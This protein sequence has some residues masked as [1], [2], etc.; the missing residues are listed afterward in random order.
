MP[1]VAALSGR[2]TPPQPAHRF[3]LLGIALAAAGFVMLVL[4]SE[5]QSTGY[6]IGGILA[7]TAGI[8][9][10]APLGIRALAGVARRAPVAVRLALRDL[11]RYQARS[12]AALA[13][14]SLAIGIA[15]TIAIS[16]SAQQAADHTLS[17]GNL[18]TDQL[19][20]WLDGNPNHPAGPDV[21]G[22]PGKGAAAASSP[23]RAAIADARRT[24]DSIARAL[25]AR[26]VI[27]LDA[28]VDES[29]KLPAGVPPGANQGALVHP[30]T[31]GRKRGWTLV[32]TP[33]V[34]SRAILDFYGI[35]ASD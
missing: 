31:E 7:T 33:V 27:Q 6:I 35:G 19:V 2:P 15:A 30:F 32:T 20:V 18:P 14:V 29:T 12:G 16:A 24:A 5:R 17:G 13:A 25:H 3:A 8:L 34:A 26:H 22:V 1:I 11:A 21:T 28:A 4:G 10:V 9:L 23:S